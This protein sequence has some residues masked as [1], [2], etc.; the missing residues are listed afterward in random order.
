MQLR[1][2]PLEPTAT[3]DTRLRLVPWSLGSE[4]PTPLDGHEGGD[5]G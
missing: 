4:G 2:P 3:R 1:S 5:S